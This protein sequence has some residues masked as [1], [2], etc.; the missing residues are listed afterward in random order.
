MIIQDIKFGIL[1]LLHYQSEFIL[2]KRWYLQLF[3]IPTH[4]Y[5]KS[6]K[7]YDPFTNEQ[8]SH[9]QAAKMPKMNIVKHSRN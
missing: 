4:V 8:K 7:W 5:L 9:Y 6:L 1:V 3:Q 2:R